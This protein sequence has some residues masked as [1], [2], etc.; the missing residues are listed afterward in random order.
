MNEKQLIIEAQSGNFDAFN[1][2]IDGHK[3][4]IYR[5]AIKLSGNKEDAE[6]IMQDTFLKAIDN[7][8]KF[9]MESSFGTWLYTIALNSFRAN[10]GKQKRM[11]LKTID[12]YLPSQ[13]DHSDQKP[14]LL[15]WSN[16]GIK[17]EQKEIREHVDRALSKMHHK[18]SLPFS[19]R[20]I[21]DLPVNE[22]ASIMK[23]SVPATKSRI[24]RARLALRESLSE[25]FKE[26]IGEK[27]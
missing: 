19:L 24:L 9:R 13:N 15:D 7:I 10:L 2:L 26:H 4:K 12:E 20:Y 8:D 1:Q 18:Y 3:D 25:L 27:M 14:G 11:D 23:L 5:L 21:E 16:P 17:Y 22:V 6:D